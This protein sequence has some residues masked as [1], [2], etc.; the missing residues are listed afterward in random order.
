MNATTN[1]ITV[2]ILLLIANLIFSSCAEST[3]EKKNNEDTTDIYISPVSFDGSEYTTNQEKILHGK[4]LANLFAC[5]NCHLSDYTGVNF[6]DFIPILDGLWASNISLTLPKLR[7]DQLEELLRDGT[8]PSRDLFL[9]PSKTSQFLSEK[10]MDAL[11]AYL[12][13]IPEKGNPTPIPPEGYKDSVSARLPANYWRTDNEGKPYYHTSEDEVLYYRSHTLPDLGQDLLKGR[14]IAQTMCS[15]CHGAALDGV[16]EDSGD[17]KNAISYDLSSYK[18][19]LK[20][21]ITIQ[22]DTIQSPFG[23][24]HA[25]VYLTNNEIENVIAYTKQLIEEK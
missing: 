18:L 7:D 11:I 9:M 15:S 3:K 2:C 23:T 10:D 21:G 1:Q 13:T 17:I 16:G 4:R 22:G 20:Q 19:L 25:S 8:H 24:G 12:R 14:L 6:G 5:N